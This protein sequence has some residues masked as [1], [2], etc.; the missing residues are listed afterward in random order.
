MLR[1]R[2]IPCLLVHNKGLIKTEKF[3]FLKYVGDPINAVKIF[4]EKEVDELIVLDIDATVEGRGPN[5]DLI[6]KLANECRMP[7]CYGGGINNVED[8]S[9][10][11][12][13][14]AEK[15]AISSAAFKSNQ[16]ISDIAGAIGGQSIVIVV[17]YKL[18]KSLFSSKHLIFTHNGT[19]NT[20]LELFSALKSINELNIGEVLINSIDS[21]GTQEGLDINTAIKARELINKPLTI[22]GGAKD[23]DDIK[24]A[25]SKLGVIG[26]AVGSYFVFKGKF[27]AVL[28][29]Y[30]SKAQKINLLQ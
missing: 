19:I 9:K 20:G 30:L 29:N 4:N 6:E 10:V 27:K 8:A 17:D 16:L 5:F 11:V 28:I 7:F 23:Y 2:I 22:L 18:V 24:N 3:K 26:I 1:P 25:V 12:S 14:G 21:D 15:V 13:L